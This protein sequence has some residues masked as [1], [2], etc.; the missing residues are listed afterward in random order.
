MEIRFFQDF[1]HGTGQKPL[2]RWTNGLPRNHPDFELQLLYDESDERHVLLKAHNTADNKMQVEYF[3]L[4]TDQAGQWSK[5]YFD[6]TSPD[7]GRKPLARWTNGLERSHPDFE[8]ELLYEEEAARYV[9]LKAGNTEGNKMDAE[10]FFL[11]PDEA[12]HWAHTHF[13]E[14]EW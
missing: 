10:Y 2:A 7:V 8:L 5:T 12:M 13:N 11:S 1:M 6:S 4:T 14:G 9:L 3:F